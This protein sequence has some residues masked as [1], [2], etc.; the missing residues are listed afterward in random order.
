M[1]IAAVIFNIA[2]FAFTG[3]VT[4]TDGIPENAGYVVF[5]LL[6]FLVPILNVVIICRS[7]AALSWLGIGPT[8]NASDAGDKIHGSTLTSTIMHIVGI[9][10][11]LVLLAFVCWAIVDQYPHPEESGVIEF[12][13]L[14]FLTP[15]LSAVVLFISGA[16]DGWV[17][18][19]PH[20]MNA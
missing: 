18:L 5:T 12:E 6:M 17:G 14:V 13:I 9:V 20:R 7:A 19:H 4:L 16:M 1:K 3:L 11:N 10:C 8:R 15:I 2:M